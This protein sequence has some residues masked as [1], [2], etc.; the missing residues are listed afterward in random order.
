[1]NVVK[2]LC[3]LTSGNR[4][5]LRR[6]FILITFLYYN[7]FNTP[8]KNIDVLIMY[9]HCTLCHLQLTKLCASVVYVL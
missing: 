4:N 5:S 8:L 3:T 6:E 9:W 2:I 7:N 1:M